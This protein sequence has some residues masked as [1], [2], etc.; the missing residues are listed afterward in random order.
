MKN[1]T[2][3]IPDDLLKKSREYAQ[4]HGS[5]LNEF[6]R[7]LLKQAINQP[8]NDPAKKLIAHSK[9]KRLVVETKNWNWNR[10]ELYD[11]KVLS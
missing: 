8:E 7:V 2:L 1:V 4:K 5:S 6:V 9:S 10:S 3:S 11:R